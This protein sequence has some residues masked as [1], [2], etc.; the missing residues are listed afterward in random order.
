MHDCSSARTVDAFDVVEA[1][2]G[3]TIASGLAEQPKKTSG[4]ESALVEFESVYA[5]LYVIQALRAGTR[6][7]RS[8]AD[9]SNLSSHAVARAALHQ[10][11]TK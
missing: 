10:W 7:P 11:H 6:G 5:R 8:A 9:K 2:H 3:S 4:K 1:W